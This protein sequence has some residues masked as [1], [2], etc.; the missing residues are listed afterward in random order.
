LKMKFGFYPYQ[1]VFFTHIPS[2]ILMWIDHKATR[3]NC[4]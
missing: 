2:Y 1:I 3:I 4:T